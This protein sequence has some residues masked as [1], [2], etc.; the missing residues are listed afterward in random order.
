MTEQL[1]DTAAA[2]VIVRQVVSSSSSVPANI[3]EGHGTRGFRHNVSYLYRA[4]GSVQELQDDLNTCEDQGYF[5]KE[6][7]EDLREDSIR[8]AKLINGYIRYL[9]SRLAE[10]KGIV[11]ADSPPKGAKQKTS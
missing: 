5:E 2:R 9:K 11:T 4:R 7:L 3:A 6:H 10:T 8:V 1:P